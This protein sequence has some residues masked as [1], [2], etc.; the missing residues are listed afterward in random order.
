[1]AFAGDLFVFPGGRVDD[2]DADPRLGASPFEVAAIRELFEE[3]GVLLAA[4]RAGGEAD[5]AA[6][7][8]ARRALVFGETTFGA[9]VAALDLRLRADLL[10]TISRWTTPPIMPR[11]FDTQFF[12][13][14]LPPGA[15]PTFTTDEV[16]EHRWLTAHDALDGMA[17]GELGM[18][19]P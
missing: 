5:P 12:A 1:M 2:G 16:V 6:L 7:I 9:V 10:T 17:A 11:R 3:A 19:V 15:E 4:R 14:E 13:A 18:W 8:G